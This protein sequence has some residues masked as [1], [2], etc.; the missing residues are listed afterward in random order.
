MNAAGRFVRRSL[1]REPMVVVACIFG[2]IGVSFATIGPA[3][4]SSLGYQTFQWYGVD[5]EKL[6]A[7]QADTAQFVR[8]TLGQAPQLKRN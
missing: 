8:E 5:R 7:E 1:D 4:R 3:V 2:A 6:A